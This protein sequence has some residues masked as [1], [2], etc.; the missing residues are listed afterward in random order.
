[1]IPYLSLYK[2]AP[3]ATLQALAIPQCL[4]HPCQKAW[5]WLHNR[6][7]LTGLFSLLTPLVGNCDFQP[8]VSASGV[9]RT[10]ACR[11]L[12]YAFHYFE[13]DAPQVLGYETMVKNYQLQPKF[14]FAYLQARHYLQAFHWQQEEFL[15]EAT[16][17]KTLFEIAYSHN[18][19]KGW[20]GLIKR[21]L[22]A[23]HLDSLAQYWMQ[24]CAKDIPATFITSCFKSLHKHLKENGLWDLHFRIIYH[25]ICDDVRR[26]HMGRLP[27][28]L[29]IKCSQVEGTMLHWL[30]LCPILELFWTQIIDCIAQ[31]IQAPL[32]MS[33]ALLLAGPQVLF[34]MCTGAQDRFGRIVVLLACRT[35]LAVWTDPLTTPPLSAWHHRMMDMVLLEQM[36][37]TK[38]LKTTDKQYVDCWVVDINL[39]F[40]QT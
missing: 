35:I 21:T 30:I 6:H 34:E 24:F 22:P 3:A 33:I 19:I 9:F 32:K 28:S 2:W 23:P 20:N 40:L 26:F 36:D 12:M 38:S 29:Y 31:C 1:M 14:F 8:G 16:F 17:P 27:S 10:W 25:T 39:V 5:R 11:G 13:E 4:L 15:R 37:Y 7:G 18:S